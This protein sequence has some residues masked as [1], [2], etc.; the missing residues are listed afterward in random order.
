MYDQALDEYNLALQLDPNN[1]SILVNLGT[2]YQAKGDFDSAIARY[3]QA[4]QID[5]KNENAKQGLQTASTQNQDKQLKDI[6]TAGDDL[7]K[8]GKYDEAL[9][10]YK[11]LLSLNP[12]SAIAYF[13]IGATYQA[14]NELD[15]AIDAYHNAINFDSNNDQYKKHIASA[16]RSKS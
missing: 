11:Q 9:Q 8:Q 5:P 13:D 3:N 2:A 6:S 1:P 16:F 10:K 4:L 14:K 12:Q 7:F 15:A